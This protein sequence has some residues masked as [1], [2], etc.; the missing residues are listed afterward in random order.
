MSELRVVVVP[1][2]RVPVDEVEDALGRIAKVLNRPVEMRAPAPIPRAAEDAARSQYRSGPFLVEVRRSV[3]TLG[4]VKLVGVAAAGSPVPT[5]NPDATLFV[6]DVDLFTPSTEGVFGELD[7]ARGAALISIRRLREAFYRRKADPMKQRA[8]LVK[9]IL[10][11]IGLVRGL[12]DCGDPSCAMSSS[13]VVADI[14]RK[15][16]RYCGSCWSRLSTG[17][18]RL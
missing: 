2:G 8:R 9:Q 18:F 17:S 6:T 16:E 5:P 3:P 14:D 15:K 1:V 12:P 4:V 13:Q 7:R 10:R 11:S